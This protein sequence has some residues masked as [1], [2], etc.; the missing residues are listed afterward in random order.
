[1]GNYLPVTGN[2]VE[3]KKSEETSFNSQP[4]HDIVNLVSVNIILPLS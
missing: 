3:S 1:M 2:L 4:C